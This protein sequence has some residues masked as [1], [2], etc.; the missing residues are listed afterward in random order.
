MKNLKNFK[1]FENSNISFEE[2]INKPLFGGK[3]TDIQT[4]SDST[5]GDKDTVIVS[6]NNGMVLTYHILQDKWFKDDREKAKLDPYFENPIE[7][8]YMPSDEYIDDEDII[9]QLTKKILPYGYEM[10]KS[11]L[12]FSNYI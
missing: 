6:L 3:I 11:K 2:F 12:N 5:G 8:E 10:K 4:K 9:P 1:Q 7:I